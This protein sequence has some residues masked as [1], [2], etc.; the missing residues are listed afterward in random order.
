MRSR[1]QIEHPSLCPLPIQEWL[2]KAAFSEGPSAVDALAAWKRAAG[3]SQY[4][5]IDFAS[6]RLL[7][8]VYRNFRRQGLADAWLP[9]LSALHRYHWLRNVATQ[10]SLLEA[11]HELSHIGCESIV[12]GGFAL[13]AGKYFDD[14]GDRPFLESELLISVKDA[15]TVERTLR[16]I[17]W[18]DAAAVPAPVAGWRSEWWRGPNGQSLRVHYR[19]LPKSFPVAGIDR[20]R[21]YSKVV[22]FNGVPLRIPDA[23]DLLLHACI[24]HRRPARD[25]SHRFLWA[26]STLRV[27]QRNGDRLDWDRL[28]YESSTLCT[29]FPLRESLTYLASVFN[30]PVPQ[31]WL[32]AAQDANVR[33]LEK[34]P[35]Y[36]CTR[37]WSR[38]IQSSSLAALA[39][40]WRDYA[41]AEQTAEREPSAR[42]LIQYWNWHLH[43]ELVRAWSSHRQPETQPPR[44]AESMPHA[45]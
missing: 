3:F 12:V 44:A 39:W 32:E 23:T 33:S 16:S 34:R 37:Q 1:C 20:L 41:A 43:C 10:R 11:I 42:G 7:P 14:L 26:A 36:R 13:L 5:D 22:E 6:S 8:A 28:R 45:A 29:L 27:L 9:Q 18:R 38:L 25:Q 30:A 24:A 21:K 35:F 4:S 15:A 17:G 31:S 2:L 19:W 40:P